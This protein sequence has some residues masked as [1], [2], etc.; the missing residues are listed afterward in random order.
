MD[1]ATPSDLG[2]SEHRKVIV[3]AY[4]TRLRQLNSPLADERNLR[5]FLELVDKILTDCDESVRSGQF[6][7]RESPLFVTRPIDDDYAARVHPTE[8]I[9][10]GAAL[11]DTMFT[12]LRRLLTGHGDRL[13]TVVSTLQHGV[14]VWL[15]AQSSSYDAF[16]LNRIKEHQSTHRRT[17]ARAIHDQLGA[18]LSLALRRLELYELAARASETP[19]PHKLSQVRESVSNAM[20]IARDLCHDLRSKDPLTSIRTALATFTESVGAGSTKVDIRVNGDEGWIPPSYRGEVFLILREALRN[21]FSHAETQEVIV[22]IDV[23]PH[24][25][26][27]VVGDHGKGFDTQAVSLVKQSSGLASMRERAELLGGALRISSHPPYG[28]NVEFRIP[29]PEQHHGEQT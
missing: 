18:N 26:R 22:I 16:L 29:L 17:L 10:A 24:E 2:L 11:F 25:V 13:A 1:E 20:A 5:H 14:F 27:A 7:P 6:V 28:T 9:R 19:D 12:E 15:Q 4:T 21:A 23:A 8:L 3:D